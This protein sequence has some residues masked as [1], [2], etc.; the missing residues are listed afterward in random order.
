M[1]LLTNLE[2]LFKSEHEIKSCKTH[3]LFILYL[4]HLRK[5]DFKNLGFKDGAMFLGRWN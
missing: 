2:T 4:I 3:E 1:Q 5:N